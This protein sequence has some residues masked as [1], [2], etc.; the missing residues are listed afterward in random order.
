ME[1]FIKNDII[2][3]AFFWN[4]LT[5]IPVF[6]K[7]SAV[8]VF[9]FFSF[10]VFRP[11]NG[12]I[13]CAT[14]NHPQTAQKMA[15]QQ[16][17]WLLYIILPKRRTRFLIIMNNYLKRVGLPNSHWPS[18]MFLLSSNWILW[19]REGCKTRGQ[20]VTIIDYRSM[21][22]HSTGIRAM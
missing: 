21:P 13:T 18:I 8:L 22:Q 19:W 11:S 12:L 9:W 5:K 17:A 3:L 15:H 2:I 1:F 7:K 6:T 14:Y 4:N 16:G 10:L 20:R